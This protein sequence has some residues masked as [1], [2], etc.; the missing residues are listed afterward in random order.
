LPCDGKRVIRDELETAIIT[1]WLL[2]FWDIS[3]LF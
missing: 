1:L 2:K 3:N